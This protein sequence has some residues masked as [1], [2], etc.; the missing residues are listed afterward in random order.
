MKRAI[1]ASALALAGTAA[2][3]E[4]RYIVADRM[5]DVETGTYR[6][7]PVIAVDDGRI[8]AIT[9][10]AAP[11][12][13]TVVDLRGHTILPGLIDMHVHLAG[14]ARI[15]GYRSLEYTD[16]FW[17]TLGVGNSRDMLR[18]GFTTVRNLGSADYAD[19]ALKQGIDGGF[20]P[21][22]RI[23]PA[24]WS[25]GATGGHCG[26]SNLLPPSYKEQTERGV[27]GPEAVR[28]QVR[29]NRRFGAGVIKVCATGGV[30]S[31]NTEP[32][33]QQMTFEE[34]KAAADEAHMLGLKVAAHAHGAAGIK[35]AIRAGIDTIEHAS[36]IDDEGLR[37]AKERGTWLSMDI[38]NTEF[39]QSE[40][41]ATG[42]LE[43]NLRK[44]REVA[45]VQRDNFR[46]A[47]RMGV[48]QV[49]GSDAGVM[50]HG[51]A[52]G[53]FA[54]MVQFG[55]TPL[56]AIQAATL[57]AAEALGQ[58]GQVG[59][60]KPGAWADIVAVKGDPLADIRELADVD[61]VVKG[62]VLVE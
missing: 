50:P 1:I 36:L 61:A 55:M 11:A 41:K 43:E 47:V 5:L 54:T 29:E 52:G 15:R 24:T 31:K 6:A 53:Q 12:G 18:A 60:L 38:F 23:V 42:A 56:Q 44:D 2:Q 27:N 8:T 19:V 37:L 34:L 21:G 45:Q 14:S 28:F 3:A 33:Q 13:A 40:G 51:T 7:N 30:F 26:G 58:K 39:T 32:G 25:F 57:N 49:F 10:G 17:P 9:T 16:A 46:K 4:T 59:A 20:Y 35:E 62:G 22:P 48:R